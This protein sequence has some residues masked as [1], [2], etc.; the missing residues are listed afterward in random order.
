MTK[1]LENPERR[2]VLGL[3]LASV[4]SLILGGPTAPAAEKQEERPDPWSFLNVM[5]APDT[6]TLLAQS[7]IRIPI[8]QLRVLKEEQVPPKILSYLTQQAKA[9]GTKRGWKKLDLIIEEQ[10]LG[11]PG[12]PRIIEATEAYCRRA[13]DFM[14]TKL[15]SLGG[16]NQHGLNLNQ[17]MIT[18][19][20][21]REKVFWYMLILNSL[22]E[23]LLIL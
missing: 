2:T 16:L 13:I 12:E 1:Q 4:V 10:L 23:Q 6:A 9:L 14:H 21:N 18:Q 22:Q 19:Q 11:I 15:P 17:V 8:G 3:G 5:K 20:E 7:P